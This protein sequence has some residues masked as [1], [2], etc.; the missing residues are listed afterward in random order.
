MAVEKK[1]LL[2]FVSWYKKEEDLLSGSRE[3]ARARRRKG[4]DNGIG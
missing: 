3:D 2:G 1:G 4:V